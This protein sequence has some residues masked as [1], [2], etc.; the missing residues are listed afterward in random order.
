MSGEGDTRVLGMRINNKDFLKGT[1]DTLKAI[2]SL[3]KGV[4]NAGK[5]TKGMSS[6]GKGVDTVKTKFSALQ[7]AGVTAIATITNKVVNAGINMAKSFTIAPIID[8]FREYEKLL[9]STQTISANTGL[10][11]KKGLGQVNDALDE[12]NTY[13]DQTIYNFGQMADSIGKFT[14]AGGKG[15]LRPS[16][17]AIKGMANAAALAG[18]DVNQLNTAMYQMSQAMATGSIK[19]MDWNSLSNA[20]MGGKNMQS[21]LKMTA[22]TFTKTYGPA[23]DKAIA[24]HGN[25]RESLSEGWLS[26]DVFSKAMKVMGGTVVDANTDIDKLRKMG[27]DKAAISSIRMGKTVAYSVKQLEQ[28]GYSTE[29]AKELNKLSQSAIESATKIKTFTQLIDVVKESIGSGWAKIFRVLFGDL[30]QA[31]KL[32]TTVGNSITGAIDGMF[33]GIGAVLTQW[34]KLGGYKKLWSG[35][36]NIFKAIGN[37]L[38]PF[39]MLLSSISPGTKSAGEG[40]YGLTN[41]FYQFSVWLEKVTSGTSALAPVF[42]IL[43]WAL[44]MIFGIIGSVI[45]SY[46]DL[47]KT[48]SPIGTAL[49]ELAAA[50]GNLMMK[51]IDL[52]PLGGETGGMFDKLLEVRRAIL[53]PIVDTIVAIINSVTDL[54]NTGDFGKFGEAFKDAFGNLSSLGDLFK[55]GKEIGASLVSGL[56]DAW[57]SGAIQEM[58]ANLFN[59]GKEIGSNIIDGFQDI[60]GSGVIQSTAKTIFESGKEIGSNLIDG[61]REGWSSGSIQDT[62]SNWVDGFLSFFRGLLGINSPSTVFME[63]GWDLLKGLALGLDDF[64]RFLGGGIQKIVKFVVDGI[65]GMDRYDFANAFSVIF[66][67]VVFLQIRKFMSAL[68]MGMTTFKGF[69]EEFRGATVGL[70]GSASTMMDGIQKSFARQ[71]LAKLILNMAIALGILAVSLWVLSKIPYER[72]AVGFTALGGMMT[73]MVVAV[74]S[75]T[76]AA[77]SMTISS[78]SLV[79]MGIAMTGLA[80]GILLLTAAVFIFSKIPTDDLI[81]GGIAVAAMLTVVSIAAI[82]L[83]KAGAPMLAASA[84]V[85]ILAAGLLVLAAALTAFAGVIKLYSTMDWKTINDGMLKMGLVL[86]GLGVAMLPLA[87]MAPMLLAASAALVVLS[88]GMTMMLGVLGLFTTI[89]FGSVAESLAKLSLV[90]IGLGAAGMIAAPGLV[91]LGVASVLLGV[92]LLAAGTGMTLLAAGLA[93][94]TASGVASM[95]VITAAFEAFV[96]FLPVLGVQLAAALESFLRALADKAPSIVDSVIVLAAQFTRAFVNIQPQMVTIAIAIIRSFAQAIVGQADVLAE[97]GITMLLNFMQRIRDGIEPFIQLG[98]DIVI[99]LMQGLGDNSERMMNAA[100]LMILDFLR[101]IRL[102]I[103]MYAEPIAR[104]GRQIAWALVTGIA[105]GLI[106]EPIRRA[107]GELVNRFVNFFRNLL[108]INSPSK[109]FQGFGNDIVMGLVNGVK[110]KFESARAALG[111]LVSRIVSE[112]SKLPGKIG[113]ALSTLGGILRGKF[114]DAFDAARNAVNSGLNSI[115]NALG[116]IPGILRG[117]VNGAMNGAKA[118]GDAIVNGITTGLSATVGAIGDLGSAVVNMVKK[119]INDALNLPFQAKLHIPIPGAPDINWGPKT[120]IDR[121]AKGVTGFGGGSALV[122]ELGPELVTMG[123]GSN[124]I[125]NELLTKFIKQVS[126][127]MRAVSSIG[128]QKSP[129]G[130]LQYVVSASLKGDPKKDGA[131]FAANIAQG[132]ILGLQ[133]QKAAVDSSMVGLADGV[134]KAFADKMGIRS[135]SKVFKGLGKYLGKGLVAGLLA[136]VSGV[137]KAAQALGNN[138]Y[139]ALRDSLKDTFTDSNLQI[140]K[141]TGLARAYANAADLVREKADKAKK[142]KE[143]RRLKRQAKELDEAAKDQ[144]ALAQKQRN[145]QAAAEKK[146]KYKAEDSAGKA[147]MDKKDAENAAKRA[148]DLRSKAIQLKKEAKLVAKYDK[149][150]AKTLRNQADNAVK[151]SKNAAKNAENY[152]KRYKDNKKLADEKAAKDKADAEAKKLA[153]IQVSNKDIKAAQDAFNTY[154]KTM[155]E[156]QAAARAEQAPSEFKF[157]QN[158]YSPEAISPS[159]AYRNGKSLVSVMERKLTPTP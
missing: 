52:I 155:R 54:I 21:T 60:W 13:S 68:S 78:A 97:A 144:V 93:T 148:S 3:N 37:L 103:E 92:G 158:N 109:K 119:A 25:F 31:G 153:D 104:E 24:K 35:F 125:T 50:V 85:V 136:S 134:T 95:A 69:A 6:L 38:R 118:I 107:I 12:L 65:K 42:E 133:N 47:F 77:G 120:I 11:G 96:A 4:D 137:R 39:V 44:R 112:A 80:A 138:A 94:L 8:G 82:A 33:N 20:G 132:L 152:A 62:I 75:L 114:N 89:S 139:S 41:A 117:A 124:V 130:S 150:R 86:V 79:A 66:S 145:A 72:L 143:K 126:G 151:A 5:N 14:A 15:S 32:W 63:Y 27:F 49:F 30:K 22:S 74:K 45:G 1:A 64:A 48:L 28:M 81:K 88:V 73:M 128:T 87:A 90:L 113:K 129:G 102:A 127:F 19:L 154:A 17:D 26:A 142:Q 105:R 135:P 83:S 36:G 147:E 61:I 122:G 108:G 70:V 56:K 40:L 55:K 91:A 71:A 51:L 121:F 23:M 141:Y 110:Q 131:A 53:T 157:E 10:T 146:A 18:S 101:S 34:K 29:A 106:P 111:E 98:T 2:D 140:E 58:A 16:V 59:T 123:R 67:A 159:E 46:I 99:A 9:T 76:K 149:G 116:K 43:G 115:S 7:V 100:G 156:A 57:S 84:G